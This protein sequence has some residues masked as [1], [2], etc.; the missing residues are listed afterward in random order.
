MGYGVDELKKRLKSGG[1]LARYLEETGRAE[2]RGAAEAQ[3]KCP[4]A[5]RHAH[6]DARPSAR[7]Y[8]KGGDE[9]I[10][11]HGCGGHWDLFSLVAHDRGVSDFMDNLRWCAERFGL[12][13]VCDN[14]GAG[15]GVGGLTLPHD[16]VSMYLAAAAAHY[17]ETDYLKRRGISDDVARRFG[18]GFDPGER[19]VVFPQ[20]AGYS[21]RAVDDG[22]AMRYKYPK[23]VSVSPF[24]L[25]ALWNAE[26]SPVFIV[27]GQIDA[28]SVIEAGGVAVG[29][30]GITHTKAIVD[31]VKSRRVSVPLCV[32][33]D[34]DGQKK[35]RDEERK[36]IDA[37]KGLG[38]RLF[39]ACLYPVGCKDANDA[40]LMDR[41]AF[42]RAVAAAVAVAKE[43][44]AAG[45][46]DR[47]SLADVPEPGPEDENPR[48][49][50]KN[51]YLRKGQG[52]M[53][54]STS[55]AGKSVMSMQLAMF[56][57][58]GRPIWGMIPAR[59]LRI[60]VV[61]AE[62]DAEELAFFRRNLRKGLVSDYGWS[63]ADVDA[64]LRGVMFEN[65]VGVTGD[66]FVDRLAAI[67]AEQRYDVVFVNPLFS[68]FG[69]DLS[70]NSDDAHFFR[71]RIDPLIK[72]P[73]N[74][75]AIVFVHHANKP[76]KGAERKG[77]G[78]DA[79]AQYIG[80]GGTDVAGW[81]RAQ[82][83][84]M[85]IEG[86]AGWFKLIAAKR[87]GKLGWKDADGKLTYERIIA[88]G[89][90]SVYWRTPADG[91]IPP[92]ILKDAAR[93]ARA[94]E[95]GEADARQMILDHLR[96]KPPMT[97]TELFT[98]C[99][100]RFT[101][102]K[103]SNEKPC[104]MAYNDVVNYP[105]RYGLAIEKGKRGA[106]ILRYGEALSGLG[107][108]ASGDDVASGDDLMDGGDDDTIF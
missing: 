89:K 81:T 88:Y 72:D 104:R 53:I 14:R 21:A 9:H 7:Y 23:G 63:D 97:C 105:E 92:E 15:G 74:G 78:L 64:A 41:E 61:Q 102:F 51:G 50:L 57:A 54:V 19:R 62:D 20:G 101:G 35:T 66:A 25:D 60:G 56:W 98:W 40:L 59:K 10:H 95:I 26:G 36:L 71:E 77:W 91:D 100:G 1:Y 46:P 82:L 67:Q 94:D 48:A 43:A 84:V 30:G 4:D 37:L 75:C 45:L 32:S 87:G 58:M 99:A 79:F 73:Y 16:T 93:T 55:G 38:I 6:G 33:F 68:F 28:L 49:I 8:C 108:S 103:S 29:L 42:G 3:M 31:A 52:L 17:G 22:N 107:G 12:G 76:P 18:V 83:V 65:V 96:T 2:I 69:G 44:R 34:N 27:E 85:P 106:K 13:E 24:N 39:T 11:C 80:A 86:H 5:A 70:N 47:F 90:D